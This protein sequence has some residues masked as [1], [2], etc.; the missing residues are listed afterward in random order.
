MSFGVGYGDVV[1]AFKQGKQIWDSFY[2]D[3]ENA[4]KR[5]RELLEIAT[6]VR[7]SV[8][9]W[10]EL[11]KGWGQEL[12]G[13]ESIKK[14]LD[15]ADEFVKKYSEL[16]PEQPGV[17]SVDARHRAKRFFKTWRHA[18]DER[19]RHIKEGLQLLLQMLHDKVF[20]IA[21]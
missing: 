15:E 10:D 8:V 5:I 11:V 17:F 2:D 12:P 18:F 1:T 9:Q 16:V 21:L 6:S 13:L 20:L 3:F 4:P 19:A 7:D 14:K